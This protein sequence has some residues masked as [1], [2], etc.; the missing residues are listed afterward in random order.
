MPYGGCTLDDPVDDVQH[1]AAGIPTQ[2]MEKTSTSAF[3][4]P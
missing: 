2:I 1:E 4:L 3:G